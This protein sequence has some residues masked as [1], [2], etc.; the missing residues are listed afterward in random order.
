MLGVPLIF[1]DST[2]RELVEFAV[3]CSSNMAIIPYNKISLVILVI[4]L[5]SKVTLHGVDFV[6]SIAIVSFL[7]LN[8]KG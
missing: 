2:L 5:A 4:A 3:F 7:F 1:E 8:N 6:S